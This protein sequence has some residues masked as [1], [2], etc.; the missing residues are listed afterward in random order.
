MT[1]VLV[2]VLIVVLPVVLVGSIPMIA[3]IALSACD[4]V[5]ALAARL[6]K[7]I[8]GKDK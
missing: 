1:D 8:R 4:V 5:E 6:V 2:F 3:T 7:E